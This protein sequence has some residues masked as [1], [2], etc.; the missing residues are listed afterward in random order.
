MVPSSPKFEM[1]DFNLDKCKIYVYVRFEILIW[2]LRKI[3]LK[4]FRSTNFGFEKFQSSKKAERNK[5][6]IG[7]LSTSAH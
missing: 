6:S 1:N 3:L 5:N 2:V 4:I 7:S